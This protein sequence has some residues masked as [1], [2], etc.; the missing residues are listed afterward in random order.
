[1]FEKQ[2]KIKMMMDKRNG[3]TLVELLVVISILVIM[4]IMMLGAF[5]PFGMVNR[6]RDTLRKKDLNRIKIAFEEYM[7]D[8]Q[9]YPDAALVAEMMDR[10]NC[11]KTIVNF[12]DLK[13]WPCDPNGNP[14]IVIVYSNKFKI[15]TNL[16]NKKDTNILAGWYDLGSLINI[17]GYN[18]NDVNYGVSSTN[19]LWYELDLPVD[20]SFHPE[21]HN[22][23]VC[24]KDTLNGGCNAAV[25]NKDC[26]LTSGITCYAYAGGCDPR[27]KVPCCG[28]GCK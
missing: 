1:M 11:N 16:E 14:Y 21:N 22:L 26:T 18:I 28:D 3:F 17:G 19:T 25:E 10:N 5:D 20:C 4:A 6:G 27:C 13:P 23:D 9:H 7:N 24:N 15:L 12:P 2:C 8:N